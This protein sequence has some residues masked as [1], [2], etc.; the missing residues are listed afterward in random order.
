[1]RRSLP[2]R[3]AWIEIADRSQ[4]SLG[5]SRRS[6]QGERGSKCLATHGDVCADKVAPRKGSVDRNDYADRP[7]P[8]PIVSLPARGAW[9][10][11]I[12]RQHAGHTQQRRS[13]QGERGSKLFGNNQLDESLRR[14]PQ[15]ERGSKYGEQH[16]A[17]R[18][19]G[20][21]PARGAWIEIPPTRTAGPRSRRSPQG[22]RGSK[23]VNA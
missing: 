12:E 10:E 22:E 6:P 4:P 8:S 3:G 7:L 5:T 19:S 17:H 15:G 23:S 9:I 16:V 2:A 18:E 1:M 13:P 11:M 14:S 21:L 20:S